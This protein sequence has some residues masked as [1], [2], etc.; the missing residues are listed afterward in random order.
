MLTREEG[1][2]SVFGFQKEKK[3]QN[4]KMPHNPSSVVL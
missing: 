2:N 1:R 4:E 3:K